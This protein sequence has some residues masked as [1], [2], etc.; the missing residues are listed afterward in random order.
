MRKT[1]CKPSTS[2]R[3]RGNALFLILIAIALFAALSYAITQSERN[4]G[5]INKEQALLDA[6]VAQQCMAYV[7]RGA[8][9]LEIVGGCPVNQISYELPNGS[10]E[11]PL[12]TSDTSCFLFHPDGAGLTACGPYLDG[13]P[14]SILAALAIGET[15]CGNI[16]YAGISGG[17][18]IYTTLA[19]TG[20]TTVWN[21]GPNNVTG[22]TSASDGLANTNTLVG[23]SD[24]TTPYEAS[25]MCRGLGAQWYLPAQDELNLFY[26]NNTVG[27]MSGT[28]DT[29]GAFY[30]SSTE[31]NNGLAST[32]QFNTGSQIP[33]SK[34]GPRRVR[35]ARR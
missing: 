12:N 17:N 19:D 25:L 16:V 23:L 5:N 27:A 21:S 6:A 15:G 24:I 9:T 7:E 20:T 32:K 35:C 22:A 30:W 3:D 10:N 26:T 34:I 13:C 29:S 18:R 28:F 8:M 31:V 33:M 4:S 14:D 2:R 1:S 11:S